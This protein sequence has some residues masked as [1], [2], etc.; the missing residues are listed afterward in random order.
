MSPNWAACHTQLHIPLTRSHTSLLPPLLCR[1]SMLK[2][3]MPI[4]SAPRRSSM[5]NAAIYPIAD[6]SQLSGEDEHTGSDQR[7][8]SSNRLPILSMKSAPM[9]TYNSGRAPSG[10][11][12]EIAGKSL[13]SFYLLCRSWLAV[14]CNNWCVCGFANPWLVLALLVDLDPTITAQIQ[15]AINMLD[16]GG[17]GVVSY[18]GKR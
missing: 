17:N 15:S 18:V 11:E 3:I 16:R 8:K 4:I 1:P 13:A 10:A 6:N 7:R 2:D 5:T 9:L 12:Q 14:E